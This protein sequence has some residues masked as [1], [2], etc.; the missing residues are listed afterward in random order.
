[1]LQAYRW[2]VVEE[3]TMSAEKNFDRSTLEIFANMDI[4]RVGDQ[5]TPSSSLP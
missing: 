2:K 4:D 5:A 3:M 1:V